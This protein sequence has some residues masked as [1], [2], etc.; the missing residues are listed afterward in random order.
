MFFKH[1]ILIFS[2]LH[3][4]KYRKM[5]NDQITKSYNL[6]FPDLCV[7]INLDKNIEFLTGGGFF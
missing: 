1:K 6:T 5:K 4:E 7:N 2:N 3:I